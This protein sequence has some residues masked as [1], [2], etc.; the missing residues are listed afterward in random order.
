[1]LIKIPNIGHNYKVYPLNLQC[2]MLDVNLE[3]NEFSLKIILR[4]AK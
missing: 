1:M 3:I 2:K 4:G